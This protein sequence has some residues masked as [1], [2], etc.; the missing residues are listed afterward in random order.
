MCAHGYERTPARPLIPISENEAGWAGG[1][2]SVRRKPSRVNE[3]T[4]AQPLN[5]VYRK[6]GWEGGRSRCV[7]RQQCADR[8]CDRGA[9]LCAHTATNGRLHGHGCVV[10]QGAERQRDRGL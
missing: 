3:R 6:R 8:A 7:Q 1:V 9:L 2:R 4:P 5:L 10:V